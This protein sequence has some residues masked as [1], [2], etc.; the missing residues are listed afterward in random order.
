MSL[1]FLIVEDRDSDAELTARSLSVIR[2][3]YPDSTIS[4]APTRAEAERLLK[5]QKPDVV[6]ADLSLSDATPED[7]IA[8]LP[9]MRETASV[10]IVTGDSTR[11]AE[12]EGVPVVQKNHLA[13][14]PLMIARMLLRRK[15]ERAEEGIER[16]KEL[17]RKLAN[18]P[19]QE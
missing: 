8:A 5:D 4:F 2:S 16:L 13:D 12:L 15:H 14:L 7:I 6:L 11:G 9:S 1:R 10:I 18:V 19:Q 3:A 17:E